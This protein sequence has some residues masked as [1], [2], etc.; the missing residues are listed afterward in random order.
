MVDPDLMPPN[1]P[2]STASH[3]AGRGRDLLRHLGGLCEAARQTAAADH[4]WAGLLGAGDAPFL[5]AYV[6]GDAI[7]RVWKGEANP[8]V[9]KLLR[10]LAEGRDVRLLGLDASAEVFGMPPSSS[11]RLIAAIETPT[12]AY[13]CLCLGGGDG[14]AL[15]SAQ[16]WLV[17]QLA[18]RL[19]H[20]CERML[21]VPG[22]PPGPRPAA[23]LPSRP[24][25]TPPA[26]L[27]QE[28]RN[29]QRMMEVGRLAGEVAH[30][31][32]NQLT[33]ILGH[34]EMV[35]RKLPAESPLQRHVRE[36]LD[37][38]DRAAE[39][40]RQLQTLSHRQAAPGEAPGP[41]PRR[42]TETLLLVEDEPAVR[43]WEVRVLREQGYRVLEA[44][45]GQ[46][47]LE[48]LK[49]PL[50]RVPDLLVTDLAMPRLDGRGLSELVRGL[51]PQMRI[52]RIS[53]ATRDDESAVELP[54]AATAFLHKPFTIE[55]LTGTI[56]EVLEGP[57]G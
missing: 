7:R 2:V 9:T 21:R 43:E 47:A 35:L 18:T 56:R 23:V 8:T 37:A 27:E 40:T 50:D 54:S 45:D 15:S 28:H 49:G 19:A 13:G 11:V 42:A 44:A 22:T 10:D 31:F 4:A 51:H 1:A 5:Q 48:M 29:A 33:T 52:L 25:P 14:A 6:S 39:L 34:G 53:G 24:D 57:P 3:P 17:R 20:S 12:R 32:N 16:E 46:E 30:D 41:G 55:E 26:R 36:M 38:V